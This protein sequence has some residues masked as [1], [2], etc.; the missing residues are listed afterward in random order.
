MTSRGV[1]LGSLVIYGHIERITLQLFSVF[2]DRCVETVESISKDVCL[3]SKT[4]CKS[5]TIWTETAKEN[6]LF[7]G[8][9]QL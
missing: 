5:E 2:I 7:T 8:C 9:K 6:I 1:L 3:H 4:A